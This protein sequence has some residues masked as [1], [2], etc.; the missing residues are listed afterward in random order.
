M[1]FRCPTCNKDLTVPDEYAGQ[2][3][4]C[5]LCSNVFQAPALP[6]PATYGLAP[7]QP[8]TS[9]PPPPT[10]SAPSPP[11]I[12]E[13]PK[14]PKT[15]EPPVPPP[16]PPPGD[17]THRRSLWIH[18]RIVPFVAPVAH[19]LVFVLTFF[20]W[21]TFY[22]DPPSDKSESW[23]AWGAAFG[24]NWVLIPFV[25]LALLAL[26]LLALLT[27]IRLMSHMVKIPPGLQQIWPWRS[28]VVAFVVFL[29]L[30]FLALQVFTGFNAS[31]DN[32]PVKGFLVHRTIFAWLA[33]LFELVAFVSLL[34]DFWLELR[35][36][37]KPAPRIDLNW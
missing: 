27:G 15:K 17:Y 33:L 4:K 37:S 30:F 13:Q 28:A 36:P 35:G 7:Q 9:P 1:D 2:L 18:P 24:G 12:S 22:P 14:P 6:P 16:P 8:P 20:P 3:M 34:I 19:F 5:P 29:A 10:A 11:P 25:F 31:V 26:P 32:I 21:L 23:M